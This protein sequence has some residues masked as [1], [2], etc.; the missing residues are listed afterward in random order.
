MKDRKPGYY[1]VLLKD[2]GV[3]TIGY[4]DGDDTYPWTIVGSDDIFNDEEFAVIDENPIKE[5][6]K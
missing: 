6:Y 1:W 4:Y 3:W 2:G 5:R